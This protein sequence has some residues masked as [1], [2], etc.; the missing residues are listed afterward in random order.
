MTG[1]EQRLRE[2]LI[3]FKES[4][5]ERKVKRLEA[6]ELR[7]ASARIVAMESA[8]KRAGIKDAIARA[9]AK[10]EWEASAAKQALDAAQ[11]ER[12]AALRNLAA[13]SGADVGA[14]EL[15]QEAVAALLD[16]GYNPADMEVWQVNG[17]YN[18][19]IKAAYAAVH[20]AIYAE[21]SAT[22]TRVRVTRDVDGKILAASEYRY[23]RYPHMYTEDT[24]TGDLID[25]TD[26]LEHVLTG[27]YTQGL[28][29][30]IATALK[31]RPRKVLSYLVRGYSTSEIAKKLGISDRMVREHHAV[32]RET[33]AR[34]IAE[35]GDI[36]PDY[37]ALVTAA[38]PIV[39]D[40]PSAPAAPSIHA[41]IAFPDG[42]VFTC[43]PSK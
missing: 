23:I 20:A 39:V 15:I 16:A 13:L 33:A 14:A 37:T 18:P 22:S 31:P 17:A 27:L 1:G 21:C 43:A 30:A 5:Y 26:E 38:A 28:K 32:I 11:S 6:A 3:W 42:R 8:K 19:A 4:D 29:G 9:D 35:Y 2:I 36:S 10:R 40:A 12:R 34:V 41:T 25:T 24:E 7:A